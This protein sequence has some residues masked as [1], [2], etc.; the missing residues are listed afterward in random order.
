MNTKSEIR[1]EAEIR[2]VLEAYKRKMPGGGEFIIIEN[3][4]KI[5]T[6]VEVLSWVLNESH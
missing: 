2:G 3:H 1:P 5:A 4:A 6:I